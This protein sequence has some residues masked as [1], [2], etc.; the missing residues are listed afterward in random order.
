[1]LTFLNG[2]IP[3]VWTSNLWKPQLKAPST[4]SQICLAHHLRN[5]TYAVQVEG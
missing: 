4:Q 5:L 1:M 3:R 2:T